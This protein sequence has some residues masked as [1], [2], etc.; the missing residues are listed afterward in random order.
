MKRIIFLF[1]AIA[2]FGVA[3]IKLDAVP[4]PEIPP[5]LPPVTPT[6]DSLKIGLLAYYT[7]NGSVVDS[8]GKSNHGVAANVTYT[9]DRN[10]KVNSALQ[11]NGLSSNVVVKDKLDL[12][13]NSIDF[14]LSVWVNLDAYNASYGSE[15]LCKRGTGSKNGWNYSLNGNAIS[16]GGAVGAT[17]FQLSGGTDTLAAGIKPIALNQWHMLTTVYD[18]N[19]KQIS[20]YIDGVLDNTAIKIPTP[21]RTANADLYI[22][23]DSQSFSYLLK[24]KLD[25]VRI[26]NR[27]LTAAQVKKLYAVT[28]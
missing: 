10:N 24:G 1:L 14:T 20:Y 5:T 17:S 16:N 12:R 23:A 28:N 7:F 13:L 21:V 8:S 19:K 9:T 25:E 15:I 22:G 26:Y 18:F 3:C 4:T 27:A 6:V 2:V 11:F